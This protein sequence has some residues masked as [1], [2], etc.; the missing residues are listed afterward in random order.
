M[1]QRREISTAGVSLGSAGLQ[2]A[3]HLPRSGFNTLGNYLVAG[4]GSQ[5]PNSIRQAV[6]SSA[7]PEIFTRGGLEIRDTADWKSA[8]QPAVG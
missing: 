5:S 4:L 7:T 2:P 3:D 8:L 1:A 6:P